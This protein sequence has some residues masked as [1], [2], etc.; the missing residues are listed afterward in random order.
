MNTE[1]QFANPFIYIWSVLQ[2]FLEP[3]VVSYYLTKQIKYS[4]R[5]HFVFQ[6][7]MTMSPLR[8]VLFCYG[9]TSVV[10]C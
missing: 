2:I 7:V 8:M 10:E 6:G 9:N 5:I 1:V 3:M 4:T